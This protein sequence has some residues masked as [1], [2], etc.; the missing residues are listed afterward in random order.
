MRLDLNGRKRPLRLRPTNRGKQDRQIRIGDITIDWVIEREGPWRRRRIS[1][2]PMTRA[3]FSSF[4]VE[5]PRCSTRRW[6]SIVIT[7]QT[8]VS[9]PAVTPSWGT[10]APARQGPSAAVRFS[11]QERWPTSCRAEGI[12]YDQIDMCSDPSPYRPYRL[13]HHVARRPLGADL[14]EREIHLS[15]TGYAVWE[16][17]TQGANPPGTVFR[18]NCLPVVEAGQGA[19]GGRRLR[20]RTARSR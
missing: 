18:D 17:E 12:G 20:A 14:P 15:K 3:I 9:G 8:F 4:A 1:S 11:R 5:D 2:R 6:A 16:A 19:A 7:Y 13:E 10:P